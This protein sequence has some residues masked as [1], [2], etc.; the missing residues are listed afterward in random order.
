MTLTHLRSIFVQRFDEICGVKPVI[1]RP[2]DQ[3]LVWNF[4]QKLPILWTNMW[5]MF[6]CPRKTKVSDY[7]LCII[8][9]KSLKTQAT[10]PSWL[11]FC[12]RN[13]WRSCSSKLIY[14]NA[15]NN[16]YVVHVKIF[17]PY[18]LTILIPLARNH[19]GSWLIWLN[20]VGIC[21]EKF[22]IFL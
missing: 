2:F 10:P 13:L 17:L 18:N 1:L 21:Q 3:I 16:F 19:D 6:F 15:D 9:L 22:Y 11:S 5:V 8:S 4:L 12:F 20:Y 7:M 14:D